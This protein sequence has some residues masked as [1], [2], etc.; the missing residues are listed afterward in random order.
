MSRGI[1][2]LVLL[3]GAAF[4]TSAPVGVRRLAHQERCP[5]EH[6]EWVAQALQKNAGDTTGHDAKGP[7]GGLHHRRRPLHRIAA[8][9]CQPG[10]S[11]ILRSTLSSRQL[12]DRTV[13]GKGA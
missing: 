11:F 5:Q 3:A 13:T 10:M 6:R 2:V 8:H 12:A 9:V 7:S 1:L 4:G